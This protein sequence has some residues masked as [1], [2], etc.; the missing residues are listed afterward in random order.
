MIPGKFRGAPR[1]HSRRRR[2]LLFLASVALFLFTLAFL[3]VFE[4][5]T[6]TA[7]VARAPQVVDIYT[8]DIAMPL[9]VVRDGDI[10]PSTPEPLALAGGAGFNPALRPVRLAQAPT[11][12]AVAGGRTL[13]VTP[14]AGP[15][16]TQLTLTGRG[17]A[18]DEQIVLRLQDAGPSQAML[19]EYPLA[20]TDSGGNFRANFTVPND[21]PW[22]Q[23]PALL[24]WAVSTKT[25]L[26]TRA[27]EPFVI[28]NATAVTPAARALQDTAT[29]DTATP[30]ATVTATP[31]M[32]GEATTTAEPTEPTATPVPGSNGSAGAQQGAPTYVVATP[33]PTS[34][35]PGFQSPLPTPATP[36][37]FPSST[38]P[39]PTAAAA[40]GLPPATAQASPGLLPSSG[41]PLLATVV[42]T[43]GPVALRS[44]PG[45]DHLTLLTVGNGTALGVLGRNGTGDWLLATTTQGIQGW[46][47]AAATNW[48]TN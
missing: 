21:P 18:P 4:L 1:E 28:T 44:Q 34:T 20:I 17:W 31:A 47:P 37:S 11:S 6:G 9:A 42:V 14:E 26:Q 40:P 2:A 45:Q 25:G 48:G 22:G 41:A 27:P 43:S 39:S 8:P 35:P 10:L 29:T 12:T 5:S 7:V 3:S 24:L 36:A 13:E 38:T 19:A 23:L 15:G 30:T 33:M 46:L 32:T 16:G